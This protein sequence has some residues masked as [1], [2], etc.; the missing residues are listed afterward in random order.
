MSPLARDVFEKFAKDSDLRV[1]AEPMYSAPRDVLQ[2]PADSEQCFVVTLYAGRSESESIKLVYVSSLS[3]SHAPCVRDVLWWLAADAWALE[4]ANR[5]IG[6]WA[7]SYGYAVDDAATKRLFDIHFRQTA[8]L[9]DLIGPDAFRRLLALYSA[10]VSLQ[11]S[12]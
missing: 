9:R 10:E 5:T 6:D 7:A 11:K 12:T 4:Q 1:T 3:E 8:T 2:P